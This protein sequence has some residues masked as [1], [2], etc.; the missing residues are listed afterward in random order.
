MPAPCTARTTHTCTGLAD[1]R[2]TRY[3]ACLPCAIVIASRDLSALM[4]LDS[5]DHRTTSCPICRTRVAIRNLK[6][7]SGKSV[8]PCCYDALSEGRKRLI[9][10]LDDIEAML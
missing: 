9:P 5:S 1:S 2:V 4:A 10:T 6:P 8:C 3:D 7:T